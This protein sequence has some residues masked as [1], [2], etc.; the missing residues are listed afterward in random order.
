MNLVLPSPLS[1]PRAM[2]HALSQVFAG[3]PRRSCAARPATL[4]ELPQDTVWA[5]PHPQGRRIECLSGALW[6]TQ[7]W[8]PHDIF[9]SAGQSCTVHLPHRLLVQATQP[10][11]VQWHAA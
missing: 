5:L 10:A 9:L 6:I 4:R 8:Q 7:D 2:A 3:Q 1:L 11:R